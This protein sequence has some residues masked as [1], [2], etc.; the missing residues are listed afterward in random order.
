MFP[1]TGRGT[2]SLATLLEKVLVQ[3]TSITPTQFVPYLSSLSTVTYIPPFTGY[4][5]LPQVV[6]ALGVREVS[7]LL[8]KLFNQLQLPGGQTYVTF[9]SRTVNS[10][11]VFGTLKITLSMGETL[12]RVLY[13]TGHWQ[14]TNDV[15]QIDSLQITCQN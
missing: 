13:L 8:T 7:F 4:A 5:D 11:Q 9:E 14:K 3:E 12:F 6:T 2:P 1:Q 15:L 10:T